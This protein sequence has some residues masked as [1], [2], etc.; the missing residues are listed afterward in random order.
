[1]IHCNDKIKI[2][3]RKNY[4]R[5]ERVNG[6]TVEFSEIEM[7][8]TNCAKE[9][10]SVSM[11]YFKETNMVY[12]SEGELSE[13]GIEI[14]FLESVIN[15]APERKKLSSKSKAKEKSG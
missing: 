7:Y 3:V 15:L 10:N 8:G 1:M 13:A 2:K 4:G 12:S 11:F 9:G 5:I 14:P 6:G